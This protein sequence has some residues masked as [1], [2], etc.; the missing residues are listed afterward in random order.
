MTDEPK[1]PP[2]DV[3]MSPDGKPEKFMS[4]YEVLRQQGVEV[5]D[6]QQKDS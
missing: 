2:R 4:V 5:P 3:I 1:T 6:E